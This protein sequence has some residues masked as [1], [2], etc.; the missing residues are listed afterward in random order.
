VFTHL[1]REHLPLL[2]THLASLG[3]E[4]CQPLPGWLL[5][6][7][8]SSSMPFESVARL[9]DVA[10]LERSSAPLMRWDAHLRMLH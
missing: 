5:G 10:F 7:F 3:I 2:T 9:W 6:G 1:M 8:A 4:P